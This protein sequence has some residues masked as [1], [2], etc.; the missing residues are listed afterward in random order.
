MAKREIKAGKTD[1][2]IDV[3]IQNSTSTGGAG[4]TGL[5][6]DSA[7]LSCYYR[8]GATGAATALTLATLA[9]IGTAHADGGFKE[10]DAT[11]MPGLYRLDLSDTIVASVGAVSLMLKGATNMAPTV[12]ELAIVANDPEV[13]GTDVNVVTVLGETPET[14]AQIATAVRTEMDSSSTKL[15]SILTDT[16]EIG[17][18]GAGLTAI[19]GKLPA[20]LVSGRIDASVGAMAANT[21]TASALAT[22]AVTEI[23]AGLATA[24]ALTV[25]DDFL[26]TEIAAIKAKTDNLPTD[27]A[28]ASDLAASFSTVNATLATISAKTTNLPAD[29]ADASDITS[30]FGVVGTKLDTIDARLDTE[31]PAI[32]AKTDLI[33]ADPAAVGS[34]MTLTTGERNA[35]ADATLGRVNGVETGYSLQAALRVILSAAGGKVSGAATASITFRDINDTRNCIVASVDA[36][37]NRSA[38]AVTLT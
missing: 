36:D 10:I 7:G 29:P 16:A 17:A 8:K 21:L 3:F 33:P 25:V 4:L 24:A 15:S 6:F 9:T 5:A 19:T 34:A 30:A 27:P 1:Q 18:A 20:A 11:T 35:V 37:G 22:D 31:I 38:V 23:Q 13:A 28:D 14:S 32:K 2:T 12:V 26:D